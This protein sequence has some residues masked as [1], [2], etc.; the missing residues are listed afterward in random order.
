MA[1]GFP[2]HTARPS[3]FGGPTDASRRHTL[4][5]MLAGTLERGGHHSHEGHEIV[6][7]AAVARAE[8]GNEARRRPTRRRPSAGRAGGEEASSQLARKGG[9]RRPWEGPTLAADWGDRLQSAY[10]R[11][12]GIGR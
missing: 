6:A 3:W 5:L 1:H 2:R 8:W 11:G 12:Q 7:R 9:A 4:R 10:E